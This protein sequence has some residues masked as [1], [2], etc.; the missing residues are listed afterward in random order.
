MDPT[1]IKQ[2]QANDMK[3]NNPNPNPNPNYKD[4]LHQKSITSYWNKFIWHGGSS[5]DAWLN[6]GSAQVIFR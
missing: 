6:A 3:T 1:Y 2:N 4:N 5:F